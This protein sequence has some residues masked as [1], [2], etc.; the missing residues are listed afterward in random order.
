MPLNVREWDCPKCGINHDRD[1]NASK[2]VLAAGLAVAVCGANVRPAGHESKGRLRETRK[3][4]K[5]KPQPVSLRNPCVFRPGRMSKETEKET[6]NTHL[7]EAAPYRGC[8]ERNGANYSGRNLRELGGGRIPPPIS[9][10]IPLRRRAC[11]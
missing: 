10:L 4:R 7:G 9:H 2:N 3:G 8:R 1:I 6:C 5:Q 11:S